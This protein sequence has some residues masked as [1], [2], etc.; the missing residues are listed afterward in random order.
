M[1]DKMTA[2]MAPDNNFATYRQHLAKVQG[3]CLPYLGLYLSDLVY[4]CE[5]RKTQPEGEMQSKVRF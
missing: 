2:F 3:P 1:F 4:M 5:L